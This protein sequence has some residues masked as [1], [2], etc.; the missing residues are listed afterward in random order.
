[1][2]RPPV[3]PGEYIAETLEELDMSARELA[4]AL[5]IPAN[6]ITEIIRGRRGV[7]ADTAL[8]LGRWLGTGPDVWMNLQKSWELETAEQEHGAEI[9]RAVVPRPGADI[10]VPVQ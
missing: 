6:R 4:A 1:M 3:H 5:D 9:E 7:S 8:R 10:P 2:A